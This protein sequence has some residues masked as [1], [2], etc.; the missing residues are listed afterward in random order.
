MSA[1]PETSPA[2]GPIGTAPADEGT[3]FSLRRAFAALARGDLASVRVL[4]GI[5]VIWTIFQIAN[6]RF[7]SAVNLSNLTLQIAATAT[8]S[9]GV[10]L[11][12]LLGEIDLSVGAVSGLAAGVM[13][14]LSVQ[15]G[16]APVLGIGAGLAVGV[17]IGAFNG[18]IVTRFGVPSFVV[19]LAGLLA[20]QGAL[21]WVLGDTGSVNLPPSLITDLT[22]TFFDPVVGWILG[23]AAIVAYAASRLAVRRRREAAGSR[24]LA[25]VGARRFSSRSSR[26][27]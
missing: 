11:V 21:L 17:A 6:D 18:F 24:G 3:S 1:E 10:V 7:L 9:I 20:W 5:A 26:W 19:T 16:W 15:H 12:L 8:I 25:V 22:T 13:A 27:R 14:V 2:A 4:L 23:T